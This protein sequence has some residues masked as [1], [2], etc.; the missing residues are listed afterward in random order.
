MNWVAHASA[1]GA[2]RTGGRRQF[3]QLRGKL[4]VA[5]PEDPEGDAQPHRL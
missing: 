5:F 2:A 3:A 4:V 1:A